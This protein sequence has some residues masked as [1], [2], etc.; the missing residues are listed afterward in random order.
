MTD[1]ENFF[2]CNELYNRNGIVHKKSCV[3][4]PQQNYVVERKHQ[5]SLNIIRSLIFQSN[6]PKIYWSYVV[7]NV[8]I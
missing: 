6:F 1:S 7:S 3:E 4:T 5:N 8:C 2:Y